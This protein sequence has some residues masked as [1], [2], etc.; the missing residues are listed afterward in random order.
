M[1]SDAKWLVRARRGVA[2][3]S[4]VAWVVSL[5]LPVG[6][7]YLEQNADQP[8]ITRGWEVLLFGWGEP[9]DRP[10]LGM[11]GWFANIPWIWTAVRL[12]YGRRAN[13][14]WLLV[15]CMLAVGALQPHHEDWFDDHG[16]NGDTIPQFGLY[17]WL[18]ALAFLMVWITF[19]YF[20]S[21]AK[22]REITVEQC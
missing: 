20:L 19:D 5:F 22:E 16:V 18:S 10:W 14:I 6:L 21:R 3:A 11:F 4:V 1:T 2:L 8:Q 15:G 12:L 9:I 13:P 17:V 7:V